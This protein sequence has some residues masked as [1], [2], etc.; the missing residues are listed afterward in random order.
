MP[1]PPDL[2][3]DRNL[4]NSFRLRGKPSQGGQYVPTAQDFGNFLG[5]MGADVAGRWGD[6]EGLARALSR[7]PKRFISVLLPEP[8]CPMMATY[9]FS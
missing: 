4:V 3:I 7:H 1:K 8:L 2:A 5:G 6:F 9:S